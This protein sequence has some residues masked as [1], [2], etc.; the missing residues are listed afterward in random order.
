MS[1]VQVYL[2]AH[3]MEA[4]LQE[5]A[6]QKPTDAEFIKDLDRGIVPEALRRPQAL[7]AFNRRLATYARTAAVP[8]LRAGHALVTAETIRWTGLYRLVRKGARCCT[9][10]EY[11]D[12]EGKEP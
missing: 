5:A 2:Q 11:L 12:R 10:R 8:T 9:I 7:S 6:R 1:I 4:L 3:E